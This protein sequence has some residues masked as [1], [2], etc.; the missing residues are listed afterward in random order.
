MAARDAL[1]WEVV[2]RSVV[3]GIALVLHTARIRGRRVVEN[4]IYVRGW[5]V[6]D[7]RWLTEDAATGAPP[8]H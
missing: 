1:P 6:E 5:Q 2:C 7:N 8:Q 3:D 4:G